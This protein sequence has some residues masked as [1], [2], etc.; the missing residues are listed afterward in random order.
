MSAA[1]N[2]E[3]GRARYRSSEC[4]E[5]WNIV[6]NERSEYEHANMSETNMRNESKTSG[7]TLLIDET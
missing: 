4:N 6:N 5:R 1:I 7:V 3:R 2:I